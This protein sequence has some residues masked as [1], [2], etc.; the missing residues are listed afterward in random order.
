MTQKHPYFDPKS[1][2]RWLCASTPAE[3]KARVFFELLEAELE[4]ASR[5]STL[6]F[7]DKPRKLAAANAGERLLLAVCE[8]DDP[9]ELRVRVTVTDRTILPDQ[10]VPCGLFLIEPQVLARLFKDV[11]EFRPK[12]SGSVRKSLLE[13]VK[14]EN[15]R[16]FP[17]DREFSGLPEQRAPMVNGVADFVFNLPRSFEPVAL[18]ERVHLVA[19]VNRIRE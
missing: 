3:N 6:P 7:P 1:S 11:P 19:L 14:R 15:L 10:Q 9:R 17:V 8:D 5:R 2:F 16:R 4:R 18:P 12:N 13:L